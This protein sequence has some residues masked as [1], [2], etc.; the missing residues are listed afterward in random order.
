MQ[1]TSIYTWHD[2]RSRYD[3]VSWDPTPVTREQAFDLALQALLD[4]PGV[5]RV[6][7]DFGAPDFVEAVR[8]GFGCAMIA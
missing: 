2:G 6:H 3:Q 1:G 4:D 5:T 8:G 7:V